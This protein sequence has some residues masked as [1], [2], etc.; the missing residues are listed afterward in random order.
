MELIYCSSLT[1]SISETVHDGTCN[2]EMARDQA[3]RLVHER[4][5]AGVH[6]GIKIYYV[7][8]HNLFGFTHASPPTPS[9]SHACRT[10]D[11]A[12]L[13]STHPVILPSPPIA[14]VPFTVVYRSYQVQRQSEHR[15][16]HPGAQDRGFFLRLTCGLVPAGPAFEVT[17]IPLR[18]CLAGKSMVR[19][20]KRQDR[21][22]RA[23]ARLGSQITKTHLQASSPGQ[24]RGSVQAS[25]GSGQR[26]TI[27]GNDVLLCKP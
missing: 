1:R 14:S 18:G 27:E 17:V 15:S 23:C 5:L 4:T 20:H 22:S 13:S 7:L 10:T 12:R 19:T 21:E 2:N 26:R 11:C 24:L 3:L 25:C 16:R 8:H 6:T 9:R